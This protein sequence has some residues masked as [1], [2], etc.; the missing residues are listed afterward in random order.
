MAPVL[1]QVN[2]RGE[3]RPQLL[4]LLLGERWTPEQEKAINRGLSA[5]GKARL[6]FTAVARQELGT[7]VVD[8]LAG[9]VAR[10]RAAP[11]HQPPF[12]RASDQALSSRPVSIRSW[13]VGFA[14]QAQATTLAFSPQDDRARS[15]QVSVGPGV[16]AI[17]QVSCTVHT[18]APRDDWLPCQRWRW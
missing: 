13:P 3:A 4:S 2:V 6:A 18:D 17:G 15:A 5:V 7:E 11:N 16:G 10:H 8:L 9:T 1:D 14:I 12:F